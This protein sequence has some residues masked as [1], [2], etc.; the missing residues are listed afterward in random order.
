MSYVNNNVYM[1]NMQVL[2]KL[3]AMALGPTSSDYQLVLT[4]GSVR[5]YLYLAF[6]LT[7]VNL[8]ASCNNLVNNS[9]RL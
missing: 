1:Y 2:S 7:L 6:C 3:L 5:G 8:L 9:P 4:F